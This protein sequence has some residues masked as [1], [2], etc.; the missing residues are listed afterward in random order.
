MIAAVL[1]DLDET[2]LDRTNSL[3]AFLADQHRRCSESLG[4]PPFEAWRDRFL[5]LDDR[6]HVHKSVVY[7]TILSEF[8]GAPDAADALLDDYYERCC[9]HAQAMPGMAETLDGLRARGMRLAIVTNG[10]TAFQTRHVHALGLV[11][12]VDAVLISEA[13]GLRKPDAALFLRAAERLGVPA[14]DCLFVGDN[15]TADILGAHEAG[16]QT[17]WLRSRSPWPADLA[18]PPGVV[19]DALPQLLELVSVNPA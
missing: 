15:P 19:I 10:E 13:E 17:A 3:M 11:E 18:P 2:L 4:R 6:G 5:A 7:R 9:R 12:R 8:G 1:F 16:M 14:A